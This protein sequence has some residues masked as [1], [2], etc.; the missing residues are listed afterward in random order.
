[1]NINSSFKIQ[2]VRSLNLSSGINITRKKIDAL[3]HESDYY[4]YYYI[5][6][7]I[8]Q[9]YCRTQKKNKKVSSGSHGPQDCGILE[10]CSF[11]IE[12]VLSL[13]ESVS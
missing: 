9:T 1:M 4:Y 11:C 13:L 7:S 3:T 10:D 6:I 8:I 2:N 12:D 5:P